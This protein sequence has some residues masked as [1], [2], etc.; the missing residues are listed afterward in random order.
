MGTPGT[1][2]V[3]RTAHSLFT[4]ETRNAATSSG[5]AGKDV[6]SWPAPHQVPSLQVMD[7]DDCSLGLL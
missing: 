3:L 2:Q 5:D 6:V 4:L 7:T 1:A